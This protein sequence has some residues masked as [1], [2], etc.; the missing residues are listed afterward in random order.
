MDGLYL[1]GPES[2]MATGRTISQE[3][4]P[5]GREVDASMGT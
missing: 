1:I 4:V 3:K 2:L 5:S